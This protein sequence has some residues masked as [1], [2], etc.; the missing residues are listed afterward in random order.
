MLTPIPGVG[1]VDPQ[2]RAWACDGWCL[3]QPNAGS[4]LLRYVEFTDFESA[5]RFK[6]Q[7]IYAFIFQMW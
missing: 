3:R 2:D 7:P 6:P 4:F 5:M 1:A